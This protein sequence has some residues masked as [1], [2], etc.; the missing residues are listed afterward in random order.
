VLRFTPRQDSTANNVRDDLP[1]RT[2]DRNVQ[3]PICS[4]LNWITLAPTID[5]ILSPQSTTR[6]STNVDRLV[7]CCPQHSD[8]VVVILLCYLHSCY[9]GSGNQCI[10]I[11]DRVTKR[12]NISGYSCNLVRFQVLTATNMKMTA[13]WNDAPCSLAELNRRFRGAAP[14]TGRWVHIAVYQAALIFICKLVFATLPTHWRMLVG[15]VRL[16]ELP[17]V[18]QMTRKKACTGSN[19]R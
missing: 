18:K 12:V 8:S 9:H 3:R 19:A 10:C 5:W 1:Q 16:P 15:W 11:V 4:T 17:R 6:N 14:S 13:F 7:H 2:Q